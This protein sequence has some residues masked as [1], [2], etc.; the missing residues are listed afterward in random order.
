MENKKKEMI[1]HP[2][3][4]M[5]DEHS[6]ECIDV[7]IDVFGEDAAKNFCKLNAFKYL[8]RSDKKG[9]EYVDLKKAIWYLQEWVFIEDEIC[10]TTE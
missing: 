2:E 8:W 1:N 7:M 5:K 9:N 6:Y 4:Y 10:K 3:H